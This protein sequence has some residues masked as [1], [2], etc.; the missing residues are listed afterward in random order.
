MELRPSQEVTHYRSMVH[1]DD[2]ADGYVKVVKHG[3]EL[4]GN[5]VNLVSSVE[6]VRD[7]LVAVSRVLEFKGKIK[8]IPPVDA[9][10]ECLGLSQRISG[11]KA[12]IALNW[13]PTHAT[14]L[15]GVECYYNAWKGFQN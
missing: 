1:V 5:V 9:L 4:R 10:A 6:N 7:C 8:F 13:V 12:R 14:F 11:E 2:L 15:D 3:N